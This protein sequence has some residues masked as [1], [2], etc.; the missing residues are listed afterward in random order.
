MP[1]RGPVAGAVL[2]GLAVWQAGAGEAG[3]I[4][5]TGR[6]AVAPDL[7]DTVGESDRLVIKMYH[8]D[9][10]VEKDLKYWIV[11]EYAF[12]QDF[13]IAPTVNM[14]GN[15]RWEDYVIEVYT[16]RDRNVLNLID[17]ELWVSTGTLVP[18]GT[19]ALELVLGH[20]KRD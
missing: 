19:D 8:P 15:A 16:D 13:R 14:A 20:P 5:I 2:F 9:D 3:D 17:G 12:P 11:E 7:V 6:I 4:A 1:L 10:G 18:L